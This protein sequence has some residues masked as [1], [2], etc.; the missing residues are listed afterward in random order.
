M[1][2]NLGFKETINQTFSVVSTNKTYKKLIQI[3]NEM[4][5]ILYLL[6]QYNKITKNIYNNLIKSL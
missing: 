6:H 1:I 2:Q 3:K 4:R 5:Q